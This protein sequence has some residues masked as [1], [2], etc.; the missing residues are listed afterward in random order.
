MADGTAIELIMV[1]KHTSKIFKAYSCWW[2]AFLID[3]AAVADDDADEDD[4][5]F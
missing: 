2:R 1:C 5:I 3:F 4:S